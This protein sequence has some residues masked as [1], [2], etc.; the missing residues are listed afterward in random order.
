MKYCLLYTGIII[1]LNEQTNIY[2]NREIYSEM[3]KM[4]KK[5][6]HF[7]RFFLV[8]FFHAG[9]FEWL[10]YRIA[11]NLSHKRF[12]VLENLYIKPH[13]LRFVKNDV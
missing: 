6:R 9:L 8:F 3:E 1:D 2:C 12:S 10:Y 4:K 11:P 7:W 13:F 5:L